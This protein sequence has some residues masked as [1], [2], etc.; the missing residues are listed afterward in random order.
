MLKNSIKNALLA[1]LALA[2]ILV[3]TTVSA[4]AMT[5]RVLPMTGEQSS[6]WI[7]VLGVVI[8]LGGLFLIFKR[9]NR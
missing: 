4:Y 3:K 9:K 8:L 2:M 6:W 7:I 1:L 5:S